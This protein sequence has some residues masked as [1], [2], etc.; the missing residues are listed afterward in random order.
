MHVRRNVDGPVLGEGD[1]ELPGQEVGGHGGYL[2]AHALEL[3]KAAHHGG[4]ARSV[5]PYPGS[6][7]AVLLH[8]AAR[9]PVE[10]LGHEVVVAVQLFGCEKGLVF[11]QRGRG[12]A[13]DVEAA[14]L[15]PHAVRNHPGPLR[16]DLPVHAAGQHEHVGI[17]VEVVQLGVRRLVLDKANDRLLRPGE[18][19]PAQFDQRML[20]RL[21]VRLLFAY[22]HSRLLAWFSVCAWLSTNK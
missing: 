1:F 20:V 4:A 8:N 5:R 9:G 12:Q 22:R 16:H 21:R 7:A 6:I 2:Y 19:F 11:I 15:L 10:H 13:L 18:A 3:Q 17:M 14:Q